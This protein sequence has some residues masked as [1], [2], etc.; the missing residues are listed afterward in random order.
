VKQVEVGA[1]QECYILDENVKQCVPIGSY[2][3]KFNNVIPNLVPD[4]ELKCVKILVPINLFL[5]LFFIY[6][7]FVGYATRSYG[8]MMSSMGYLLVAIMQT[9]VLVLWSSGYR[10]C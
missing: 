5:L 1:F 6:W 2:K 9:T 4:F 3:Q 7:P 8:F 10:N